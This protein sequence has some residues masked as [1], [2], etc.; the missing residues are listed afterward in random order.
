MWLLTIFQQNQNQLLYQFLLISLTK[1]KLVFWGFFQF[2]FFPLP[3]QFSIQSKLST[4][5][6]FDLSYLSTPPLGQDM[7]QGQ[8]LSGV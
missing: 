8:F 7:T 2:F 6:V 1:V 3:F 5:V 4:I